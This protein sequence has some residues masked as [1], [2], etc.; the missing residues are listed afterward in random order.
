MMTT[1]YQDT[2]YQ[3]TNYQGATTYQE[4]LAWHDHRLPGYH[5]RRP[6]GEDHNLLTGMF[7]N[8]VLIE[9]CVIGLCVS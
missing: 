6:D 9:L 3:D 7:L 8:F 5:H 1:T 2:T 4:A